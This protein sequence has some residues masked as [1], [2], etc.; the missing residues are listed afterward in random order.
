MRLHFTL[1]LLTLNFFSGCAKNEPASR[2][3][4]T[5]GIR[6][7]GTNSISTPQSGNANGIPNSSQNENTEGDS[8]D[9]AEEHVSTSTPSP[10]PTSLP[11]TST[12]TANPSSTPSPTLTASPSS[13]PSPTLTASPSSTP[14]PTPDAGMPVFFSDNF[15]GSNASDLSSGKWDGWFTNHIAIVNNRAEAQNAAIQF[16]ISKAPTVG[17]SFSVSAD[18]ALIPTNGVEEVTSGKTVHLRTLCAPE[19]T[20]TD[21]TTKYLAIFYD[22]QVYA[23]TVSG[24]TELRGQVSQISTSGTVGNL[25]DTATAVPSHGKISMLFSTRTWVGGSVH[26]R[27]IKLLI[28]NQEVLSQDMAPHADGLCRAM[29]GLRGFSID[30]FE[31]RG[32][33]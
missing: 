21:G 31:I 8:N 13:T 12:L 19:M 33:P 5:A 23:K 32:T 6:T 1:T 27:T 18:Y 25:I 20:P 15:D 17:G 26:V 7:G 3:R 10:T 28:N 24:I 2:P 30:N 4:D 29:I 9:T 16:A 22:S 11:P 14:S